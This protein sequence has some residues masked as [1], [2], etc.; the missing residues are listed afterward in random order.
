MVIFVTLVHHLFVL[1]VFCN[2]F[3]VEDA[4]MVREAI[5]ERYRIANEFAGRRAE[6]A[7]EKAVKRRVNIL[8][9][10]IPIHEDNSD[11]WV[12]CC[13][14]TCNWFYF[15]LQNWLEGSGQCKLNWYVC[16]NVIFIIQRAPT[17]SI[18][19]RW[20]NR[21]FSSNKLT[22]NPSKTRVSNNLHSTTKVQVELQNFAYWWFWCFCF[23]L[24]MKPGCTKSLIRICHIISINLKSLRHQTCIYVK[25][26]K[27]DNHWI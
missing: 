8:I 23:T 9:T 13:S 12:K 21:S 22:L 14:S 3:Y 17:H 18:W 27:L 26:E 15:M 6:E 24:C 19:R 1:Y 10:W 11:I 2:D 16:F 5:L 7:D 20:C 25:L 4:S